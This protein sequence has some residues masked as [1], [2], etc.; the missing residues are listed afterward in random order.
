[1]A[2]RE[3]FAL[4]F[5]YSMLVWLPT[6]KWP[7]ISLD[8]PNVLATFYVRFPYRDSNTITIPLLKLLIQTLNKIKN[9]VDLP[10]VQPLVMVHFLF[11]EL[12]HK[13]PFDATYFDDG[14][15]I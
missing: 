5:I 15:M 12:A 1:M 3:G 14:H 4:S 13:R 10:F 11:T 9:S 6:T 2:D 8:N 7:L